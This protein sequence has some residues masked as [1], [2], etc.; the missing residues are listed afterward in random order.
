[1]VRYILVA[2]M[3]LAFSSCVFAQCPVTI[4]P[5]RPFVPPAPYIAE[6]HD[7]GFLY[8]SDSLWTFV[9]TDA[10]WGPP[11]KK[12]VYWRAGFDYWRPSIDGQKEPPTMLAVVARRLDAPAPMVW[13]PHASSVR[14]PELPGTAMITGLE[15]PTPGCWEI[16]AH[17]GDDTLSYVLLMAGSG[18]PHK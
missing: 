10:N 4:A 15:L 14:F 12:M 18:P 11:G 3:V 13:A 2:S 16:S 1:M 7:G 8:G 9:P 6:P 5:D 17:F